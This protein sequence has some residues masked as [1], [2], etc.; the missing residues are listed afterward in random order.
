MR[1]ELKDR[2][3]GPWRLFGFDQTHILTFMLAGAWP[4]GWGLSIRF[5]LASGNPSTPYK[6]GIYDADAD[7]YIG[8]PGKFNSERLPLF[9][10]L[11]IRLDK[12]FVFKRWMLSLYLD[13]QNVYNHRASEFV[14]YNFNYTQRTYATGLPI[15]P[16]FGIKGE[17]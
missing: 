10:Q 15:I 17:F 14:S 4:R 1:S 7:V 3:D 8:V 11:D 2:P 5:R 16:S 6:G 13:V 12:K 9:H